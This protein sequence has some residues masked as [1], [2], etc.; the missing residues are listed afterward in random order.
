MVSVQSMV[1]MCV[2][3]SD[4]VV[5]QLTE[6]FRD[7]NYQVFCDNFFTSL[8]KLL[9]HGLYER[10]TEHSDQRGFPSDLKGLRLER[11]GHE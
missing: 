6:L 2:D 5:L 3:L 4:R 7:K 10:G 11:G 1:R 8:D 9:Q